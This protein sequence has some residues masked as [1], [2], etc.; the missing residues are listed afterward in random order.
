MLYYV[1]SRGVLLVPTELFVT[2]VHTEAD[3]AKDDSRS[4]ESAE[5]DSYDHHLQFLGTSCT[6]PT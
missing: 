2:L 5:R 3:Q 4:K 6:L 1:C